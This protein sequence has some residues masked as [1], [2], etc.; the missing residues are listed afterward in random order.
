MYSLLNVLE[1]IKIFRR[2]KGIIA[3]VET[4]LDTLGKSW[5]LKKEILSNLRVEPHYPSIYAVSNSLHKY[6]IPSLSIEIN[7]IKENLSQLPLPF[8]ALEGSK[9]KHHGHF[10][11]VTQFDTVTDTV[12]FYDEND[13]VWHRESLSEYVASLTGFIQFYPEDGV[14]EVGTKWYWKLFWVRLSKCKSELLL[15]LIGVVFPILA[16]IANKELHS[17]AF[18]ILSTVLDFIGAYLAAMI[19]SH[20]ENLSGQLAKAVCDSK[21]TT[22]CSRILGGKGSIIL[23]FPLSAIGLSYFISRIFVYNVGLIQNN[24]DI[25]NHLSSLS[26]FAT[27]FV[28]YSIIYQYSIKKSWCNLCLLVVTVLCLQSILGMISSPQLSITIAF[29]HAILFI[30]L[31]LIISLKVKLTRTETERFATTRVVNVFKAEPSAFWAILHQQ[32]K[33]QVSDQGFLIGPRD[34]KIRLTSFCSPYCSPCHDALLAFC[35]VVKECP[36]I[37]LQIIYTTNPDIPQF[38]KLPLLFFLSEYTNDRERFI[39][40]LSSWYAGVNQTTI[41]A[42][43]ERGTPIEINLE[44]FREMYQISNQEEVVMTPT[45]LING[46]YVPSF[47]SLPE[48]VRIIK[49]L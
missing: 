8:L 43:M 12:E 46:Y 14:E 35:K 24:M 4:L 28:P 36:Q 48:I 37:T 19:I 21:S 3:L 32:R 1:N 34:N 42:N 13:L 20:E 7:P 22:G 18:S 15:I 38:D 31:L 6:G 23:G 26:L 5:K 41:G 25:L 49:G 16:Y 45:I 11:L 29:L 47:Y 30:L 9:G 33:S 10:V 2:N 27:L 40:T 44:F 39:D 17:T